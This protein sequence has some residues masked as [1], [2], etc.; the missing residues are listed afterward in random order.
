MRRRAVFGGNDSF[1][2]YRCQGVVQRLDKKGRKGRHQEANAWNFECPVLGIEIDHPNFAFGSFCDMRTA[3]ER[4]FGGPS[5]GEGLQKASTEAWK[6]G[7]GWSMA[8][9]DRSP[10]EADISAKTIATH[11]FQRPSATGWL[12]DVK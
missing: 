2:C 4:T 3:R 1:A 6:T 8:T 7:S 5:R 9:N 11:H 12:R 10:P